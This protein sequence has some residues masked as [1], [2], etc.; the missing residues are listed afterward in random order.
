MI[1]YLYFLLEHKVQE[2][3][4]PNSL[5]ITI[6]KFLSKSLDLICSKNRGLKYL[7]QTYS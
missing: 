1:P 5:F 4:Y 2:E 3:I 6:F 7:I